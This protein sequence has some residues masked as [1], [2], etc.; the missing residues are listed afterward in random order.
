MIIILYP[1]GVIESKMCHKTDFENCLHSGIWFQ[2][3]EAKPQI[4]STLKPMV[5]QLLMFCS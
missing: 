5:K 4:H 1:F 2:Y 3:S